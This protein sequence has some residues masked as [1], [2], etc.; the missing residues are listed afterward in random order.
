MKNL[1]LTIPAALAAFT[2]PAYANEVGSKYFEVGYAQISYKESQV[3][4]YS[5]PTVKG[6]FGVVVTDGLAVEGFIA[7]GVSDQTKTYQNVPVKL[8]LDSA[9]GIYARPFVKIGE[10][11]EIFGRAGFAKAKFTGSS[12]NVSITEEGDDFSYGVGAAFNVSKNIQIGVD[13]MM[14]YSKSDVDVT[15]F[16]VGIKIGF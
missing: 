12:G 13:Y 6:A 2:A 14:Y 16:G 11:A 15:G 7:T 8:S 3:P 1:L 9:Y 4:T 10:S 5:I